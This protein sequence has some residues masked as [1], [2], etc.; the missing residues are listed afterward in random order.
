MLEGRF[1]R[2]PIGRPESEAAGRADDGQDL[3]REVH[4]GLVADDPHRQEPDPSLATKGG[5]GR[6][7]HVDDVGPRRFPQLSLLGRLP[8]D[9][10]DRDESARLQTL[11]LGLGRDRDARDFGSRVPTRLVSSAKSWLCHPG[12]DRKAPLLPFRAPDDGRKVSPLEAS[13]RY[14][15][16]LAEAWNHTVAKDAPADRLEAQDIVLTVPAS[17]DAA[18]RELTVEAA[19]AA[20]FEH[21]TLLEEPQAAFYAWLDRSGDGW[22]EQVEVG[23]LVL[24]ADVGGG[25]TDFTLIEVGEDGREPRSSRGSQSAITCCS[26]A[27]TWT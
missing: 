22:R 13:T 10:V 2:A 20:G 17:F 3:R 23:D 6:G 25:T 19:R 26:A 21:L 9:L 18:A 16:H 11:R 7:F 1:Q 15:Q 8:K 4:F 24:V 14:L 5:D 12:V 27:T